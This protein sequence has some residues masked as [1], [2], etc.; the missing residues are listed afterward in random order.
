M[1]E[2]SDDYINNLGEPTKMNTFVKDGVEY[3]VKIWKTE[4][5]T[6]KTIK[7]RELDDDEDH[8]ETGTE[9]DM[10]DIDQTLFFDPFAELDRI[11]SHSIFPKFGSSNQIDP[12]YKRFDPPQRRHR[13]ELT[14]DEELDLIDLKIDFAV[15]NEEYEKAAIWRDRKK[16]LE[17][18]RDNGTK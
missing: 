15:K 3:T 11:F 16:E 2:L 5:G 9:E 8:S 7:M 13:R 10:A 17:D 18:K 4:N 14:I 1:E 6:T 12:R